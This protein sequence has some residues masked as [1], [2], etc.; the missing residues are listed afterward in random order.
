[1][2]GVFLTAEWK[3]LV[4]LNYGVDQRI[5][6]PFVPSGTESDSFDGKTYLSLIG[7]EFNRTRLRGIPVPFHQAFEEV[8]LRFYVRRGERRGVVFLRELV[9]KFAVAAIARCVFN[10]NYSCVPMSHRPDED[11]HGNATAAE[12][13][14]GRGASRCALRVETGGEGY[15]PAAGSLSEFI[16][17][18][19]WGYAAQ[20]DGGCIEYEV[21]HPKW[22]VWDAVRSGFSGDAAE[23]YG[24]QFAEVLQ[25]EPDSAFLAEGSDVTVFNGVR[26]D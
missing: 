16:T 1:M 11:A 20:K 22:R 19:F 9:P 6:A 2:S 13:A 26:I 18:H 3:N 12:Y 25:R 17:E 4:M 8:N 10:E 21:K 24:A 7:F 15:L 23:T 14:W 5:L